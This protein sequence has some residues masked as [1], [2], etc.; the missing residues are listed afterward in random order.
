[1]VTGVAFK[2]LKIVGGRVARN[3]KILPQARST[4]IIKYTVA[5]RLFNSKIVRPNVQS[6]SKLKFL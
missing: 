4:I 2:F 1:M 6:C 3:R 5:C